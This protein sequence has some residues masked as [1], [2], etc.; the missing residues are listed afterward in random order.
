MF[1]DI[2]SM[3]GAITLTN[4]CPNRI[5]F[6]FIARQPPRLSGFPPVELAELETAMSKAAD[7]AVALELGC[8][9]RLVEQVMAEQDSIIAVAHAAAQLDVATAM[10]RLAETWRYCRPE[11]RDDIGL[12]YC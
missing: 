3:S 11:M 5:P 4:C 12:T 8:F 9:D 6:L 7:Q 10:A 1:W 2:I